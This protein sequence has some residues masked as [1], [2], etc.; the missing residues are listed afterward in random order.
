[1]IFK[2]A[3]EYIS[4]GLVVDYVF[5][6]VLA[7]PLLIGSIVKITVPSDVNLNKSGGVCEISGK[8]SQYSSCT[9]VN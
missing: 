9:V 4:S 2:I 8:V 6:L 1:V 7:E 5:Q 3:P